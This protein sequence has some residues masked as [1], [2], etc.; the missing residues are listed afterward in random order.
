MQDVKETLSNGKITW[1]LILGKFLSLMKYSKHHGCINEIY[2]LSTPKNIQKDPPKG[3]LG[4]FGK[5]QPSPS[6]L[7]LGS[8][9]L[10][11]KEKDSNFASLFSPPS[12][13]A[14]F[15]SFLLVNVPPYAS[16]SFYSFIPECLSQSNMASIG[17]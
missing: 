8:L 2:I 5:Q 10:P 9:S 1:I 17:F 14:N 11:A 3:T 12:S 16:F 15:S 13:F 6:S 4:L 7:F